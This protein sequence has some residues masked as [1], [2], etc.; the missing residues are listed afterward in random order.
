MA[1]LLAVESV[2]PLAPAMLSALELA[3][4]AIIPAESAL[5]RA[6]EPRMPALTEAESALLVVLN[7]SRTS[8]LPCGATNKSLEMMRSTDMVNAGLLGSCIVILQPQK[9]QVLQ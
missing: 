2:E 4:E 6:I 5:D 3:V 1:I 8:P 7:L 9:Y